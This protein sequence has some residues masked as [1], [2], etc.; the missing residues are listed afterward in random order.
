MKNI[1]LLHGALGSS[2]DL[3]SLE[4]A[5]KK[6]NLK[7][8]T[9]SF[10]GHGKTPFKDKFGIEQ[11]VK[12][13]EGFIK[14]KKLS[15]LTVFGY[16][17]GGYVALFLASQ[18][19]DLIQKIITLGTKFD[20]SKNSVDKETKMLDPKIISEK[21]PAFAKALETKHGE[22]WNDLLLKTADLMREIHEKEFLTTELLKGLQIPALLGL[23]DKDQMVSLE[24]TTGVFKLLPNA[25]MFMLPKTKHQLESANLN[26]LSKVILD[27]VTQ[28]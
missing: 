12:E 28:D 27:F 23:G 9:F 26:L 13:L 25:A 20:W 19:N 2:E 7:V 18:Q 8:Y 6:E 24:E 16:S 4:N 14:E 1:L 11:F 17:M 21:V 10:S 5:L 3:V 22:V 15:E